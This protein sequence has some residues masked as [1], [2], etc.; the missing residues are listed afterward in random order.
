MQKFGTIVNGDVTVLVEGEPVARLSDL[1]DHGANLGE[2]ASTVSAK[3]GLPVARQKDRFLCS[4]VEDQPHLGGYILTGAS[5]VLTEGERTARVGDTTGCLGPHAAPGELDGVGDGRASG[6]AIEQ[7]ACEALWAAYQKEAE[8]I[9]S[10]AGDDHR[11]RNHLINGAYADLYLRNSKFV[12]AGLAAYASKQVGCAMDHSLHY[13]KWGVPGGSQMASDMYESLGAGNRDL[14]LDIYP[15]HRFYE[16]HGY[17]RMKKCAGERKPPVP[18]AA[19]DGF[20]ALDRYEKTGDPEELKEHVRAIAWHEQ[21]NVLQRDI[22]NDAW[23]RRILDL[24]EGN[25]DDGVGVDELGELPK[26]LEPV[27]RKLGAKP[28]DVSFSDRCD[29]P[30]ATVIPFKKG[31]R[32]NLYDVDERMEW[33]MVDIGDYYFGHEGSDEHVENLEKLRDR[34]E[35]HGGKFP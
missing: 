32:D 29:D 27:A 20:E 28:A 6:S 26:P 31:E 33:I 22:Y 35:K 16:E 4:Q 34:G 9:I 14:F 12:W 11:H 2:G 7:A 17:D 15:L 23:I 24:N 5:S 10:P 25:L 30:N 18:A 1:S 21:V 19:L 8:G 3:H 13:K